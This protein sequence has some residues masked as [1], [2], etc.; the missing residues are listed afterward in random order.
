[1]DIKVK[2][3]ENRDRA[4]LDW[5][6]DVDAKILGGL[7]MVAE[8]GDT[9]LASCFIIP[10]YSSFCLIEFI[11][12]NPEVSIFKRSKAVR[13]LVR[14]A[15]QWAKDHG[16]EVLMGFVETKNKSLIKEFQRHGAS[17]SRPCNVVVATRRLYG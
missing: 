13:L 5:Y 10:T 4:V 11:R 2:A 12:T 14:S 8:S 1:M 6:A 9:P 7:G 17:V 3:I 16:Y 15:I